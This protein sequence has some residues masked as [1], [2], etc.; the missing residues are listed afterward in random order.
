MATKRNT[1]RG[2]F[3]E[4]S[5]R[6]PTSFPNRKPSFG[7]GSAESRQSGGDQDAREARRASLHRAFAVTRD[8]RLREELM[9]AYAGFA[10]SLAR[11]F[12]SRR[13]R[14]EDLVQVAL[15]GLFQALDRFDPDRGVPFLV[16]A[17]STITGELKRHVRDHTWVMRT[18]RRLQEDY[19]Q[20]LRAAEELTHTRGRSPTVAEI[21]GQTA[22]SEEGVLEA[23][24]VGH[25]DRPLSLD[26]PTGDGTEPL[27]TQLGRVD[28]GFAAVERRELVSALVA[29]L[30]ERERRILHLR[31]AEDLTQSEI[32]TCLGVS[33]MHVSRILART[34]ARLRTWA[35]AS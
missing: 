5:E 22:L 13:E 12:P 15:I 19:L 20:V 3:R 33:Q 2:R 29:S 35:E 30:P 28:P 21:A 23:M 4:T 25:S 11:R 16:F 24:E 14:S 32:A 34:L 17:S 27:A 18:P 10:R 9:A 6:R 7:V 26:A 8:V 1:E 31:F